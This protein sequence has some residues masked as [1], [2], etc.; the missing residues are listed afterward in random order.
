MTRRPFY[1]FTIITIS[2]KHTIHV[3]RKMEAPADR[4]WTALTEP[5]QIKEYMFGT[6]AKS[7]F[8]EGSSIEYTGTYDGKEDKPENYHHVIY[9]LEENNGISE[10]SLSQDN[11]GSEKEL[12]QMEKNRNLVLDGLQRL[13]ESE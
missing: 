10:V 9:S 4:I 2:N 7:D 12:A 8:T 1:I 11:I 3:V 13:V 5:N 6:E